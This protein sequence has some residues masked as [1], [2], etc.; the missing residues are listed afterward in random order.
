M[1]RWPGRGCV[2]AT[3]LLGPTF[4]LGGLAAIAAVP[5]VGA[6]G[7]VGLGDGFV[8]IVVLA[9]VGVRRAGRDPVGRGADDRPRD[10]DRRGEE[11]VDRRAAVRD[12][13][14]RGDHGHV[15]A[16]FVLLGLVPTRPLIVGGRRDC[17]WWSGWP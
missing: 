7:G 11:R 5:I 3:A 13:D 17:S 1:A 2:R 14:G 4:V 16:G 10:P 15:P 6:V 12:R 8:A 9:T